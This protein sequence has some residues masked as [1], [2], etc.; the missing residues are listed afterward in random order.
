M[1]TGAIIG[2]DNLVYVKLLEDSEQGLRYDS[3]VRRIAEAIEGSVKPKTDKAEMYADDGLSETATSFAGMDIEFDI[4][5]MYKQAI[6]DLLGHRIDANGVIVKNSDDTAPYVAV[7]FRNKKSNGAYRYTWLY[8]VMFALPETKYKTLGEK[9]DFQ[10]A[11]IT[12]IGSRLKF[13]RNYEATVDSDDESL[14]AKVIED[15]FAAPYSPKTGAVTVPGAPTGVS[16]VAGSKSARV[17]FTPPASNGN[18]AILEYLVTSS[19]GNITARGE[20]SPIVVTA[21]TPQT[22]Y[23]FTVKARNAAGYSEASSASAQVTPTA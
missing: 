17:S 1:R 11:K 18:S 10:S 7:G 6:H 14:G 9:I 3:E 20:G 2:F 13:D 16:A 5:D 21:L 12:A 22:Q 4:K 8:K 19:P 15:W 23:T